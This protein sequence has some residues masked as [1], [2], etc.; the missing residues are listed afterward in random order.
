MKA[1]SGARRTLH[2]FVAC[3][4]VT[5]TVFSS[6]VQHVSAGQITTRSIKIGKSQASATNVPYRVAF[7]IPTS[8]N[9]GGIVIDFCEN[10]P[11]IGDTC[12]GL[13]SEGFNTNN[14][15]VSLNNQTGITGFSVSTTGSDANTIVIGKASATSV[16]GAVSFEFGNG[17]SNGFTNHDGFDGA[18]TTPINT[19]YA[20]IYTYATQAAAQSHNEDTPSGYVD[21]GG[22][23]MSL[24]AVINITA[25]VMETLS[26]CV[27]DA[28]CGDDPS[29][30]IGHAVGTTTVI[31]D[32]AI[33]TDT[34]NFSISTNANGGAKIR[35]KGDT[36]KTAGGGNDINAAGAGT[37]T[38]AT[39]FSAGTE[40]FGLRISTLGTNI[41]T[42]APYDGAAGSYGLDTTTS[43]SDTT[44]NVT[45]LYGGIIASLSGP[46]SNSVSTITFGATASTTTP[47]GTYTAAQ[48]LIATGT[49]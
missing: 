16:S 43:D 39:A 3:M 33:D 40:A 5:A 21:Y 20:R 15:T 23:A 12:D 10:N 22:I 41:S 35:M 25:R 28:T 37:G 8:G 9:V 6:M 4:L 47:A 38:A 27:Y 29:F 46:V 42:A 7:S 13:D 11:I 34:V 31:D 19:F 24:A 18:G 14:S 30:T 48:Q 17:T 1:R 32:S 44:T 2:V 49:F 45:G 26:F 36:L